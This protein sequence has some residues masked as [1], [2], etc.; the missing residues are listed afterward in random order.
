MSLLNIMM[1]LKK[2]CN[3]PYLFPVA[4]VGPPWPLQVPAGWSPLQQWRSPSA[5]G[6]PPWPRWEV[7]VGRWEVPRGRSGGPLVLLWEVP[8]GCLCGRSPVAVVVG[9]CG[10]LG[11]SSGHYD[12]A[13]FNISECLRLPARA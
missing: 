8:H 13:S 5:V 9:P 4:V 11:R 2:C 12:R 10:H 6:G 1:D 7:P 3:H